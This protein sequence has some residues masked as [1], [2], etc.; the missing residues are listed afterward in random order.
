M[1]NLETKYLRSIDKRLKKIEDNT[2]ILRVSAF[3]GTSVTFHQ[4]KIAVGLALLAL[5]FALGWD[6]PFD[7]SDTP[8]IVLLIL[9]FATIIHAALKP[10]RVP[11]S[12]V[13]A[14]EKQ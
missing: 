10:P 3:F 8:G 1:N 13:Q 9:G 4:G 5:S 11:I 2:K 12:L 6:R 14:I 7:T